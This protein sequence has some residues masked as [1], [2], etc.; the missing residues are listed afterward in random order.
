MHDFL[1]E[2]LERESS[3]AKVLWM[4]SQTVGRPPWELL[5]QAEPHE[6]WLSW[7]LEMANLYPA[8]SLKFE[9]PETVAERTAFQTS[10]VEWDNVLTGRALAKFHGKF[11]VPGLREASIAL[12][13]AEGRDL[14]LPDSKGR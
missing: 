7:V 12:A 11:I 2:G 6:A 14:K 1:R 8:G 9:R 4:S 3:L 5:G 10:S 13:K